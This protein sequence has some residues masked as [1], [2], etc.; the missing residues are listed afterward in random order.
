MK[1]NMSAKTNF[2]TFFYHDYFSDSASVLFSFIISFRTIIV[3]HMWLFMWSW[4]WL[5]GFTRSRSGRSFNPSLELSRLSKNKQSL[6]N[7]FITM[8]KFHTMP[9]DRTAHDGHKHTRNV[10]HEFVSRVIRRKELKSPKTMNRKC[11]NVWCISSQ[12]IGTV[13]SCA[14]VKPWEVSLDRFGLIGI[15]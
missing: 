5:C 10:V 14:T 9:T 8:L 7:L 11:G 4:G 13:Q 2:R 3:S 1:A 6:I 12:V 15:A